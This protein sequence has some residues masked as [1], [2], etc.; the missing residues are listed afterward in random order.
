MARL[1]HRDIL[2]AVAQEM[3]GHG[4]AR[5][6]APDDHRVGVVGERLG[7][8]QVGDLVD[9]ELPVAPGGVVSWQGHGNR[10]TVVHFGRIGWTDGDLL[11]LG[12]GLV[13]GYWFCI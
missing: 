7:G 2:R 1:Y 11:Y 9:V 8:A 3:E 5:D 12:T 10:C 13:D 4:G 6:A